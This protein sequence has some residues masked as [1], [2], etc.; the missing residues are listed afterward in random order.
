MIEKQIELEKRMTEICV[1]KFK[2]DLASNC[3]KD[4]FSNTKTGNV[5]LSVVIDTYI[6]SIKN[7]LNHYVKGNAIR[8][9]IAAETINKVG[10]DV[11]GYIAAKVILNSLKENTAQSVYRAVGQ[12]LE[13][14]FKMQKYRKENKHYYNTIQKDLNSRGAKAN[15]KKYITMNVFGNRLDFHLDKWSITEKIQTGM[16]LVNL[17]E[18]NTQLI[19][20]RTIF[21]GKKQAR[22]IE[23]TEHL[24]KYIEDKQLGEYCEISGKRRWLIKNLWI[25]IKKVDTNLK[26]SKLYTDGSEQLKFDLGMPA[27]ELS[28]DFPLVIGYI[29]DNDRSFIKEIH[30]IK[31]KTD[32]NVDW[33]I[34]LYDVNIITGL[35]PQNIHKDVTKLIKVK[36]PKDNV[37]D[38]FDKD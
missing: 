13:D 11:A 7:Y 6:D 35:V 10:A 26:P 12:A 15:R 23:S 16:I 1:D 9:T 33:N 2:R 21:K 18:T 14:E 5:V 17:F 36:V 25:T 31:Y 29:P 4:N 22:V 32:G 20:I 28:L 19:T 34:K 3:Q 30:V 37:V 24:K 27:A 8:C 38:L